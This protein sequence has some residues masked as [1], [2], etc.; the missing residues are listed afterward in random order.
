MVFDRFQERSRRVLE[1]AVQA[2][3]ALGHDAIGTEHVLLALIDEGGAAGKA[4]VAAG[5]ASDSVRREI[6]RV[7]RRETGGPGTGPLPFMPRSKTVLEQALK[8][9]DE[10]GHAHISPE[11]LLVGILRANE[12]RRSLWRR[13]NVSRK[14]LKRLG[15]RTDELSDSVLELLRAHTGP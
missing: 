5:A 9:A 6:E 4:L 13:D 14:V 8:A 11:H 15:V 7:S 2:A 10:L 12:K 1:S 3:H